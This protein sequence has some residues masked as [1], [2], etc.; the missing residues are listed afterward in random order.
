MI[1][2]NKE[3]FKKPFYFFLK[4]KGDKIS[5]HY[6][7]SNTLNEAKGTDN[8]V[9]IPKKNEGKLKNFMGKMMMKE[10]IPSLEY[11]T[12]KLKSYKKTALGEL[13]ETRLLV[14]IIMKAAKDYMKDKDFK[15][16]DEDKKFIK[17]QSI[18]V[19]K[20]IPLIVFQIF[21]GSSLAT[22]FIVEFA[23]KVGIKLTSE[24]PEKYKEKDGGE[25]DELVDIDG[26][27]LGSNIPILQQNMH[28]NKTLD[29]TVRMSRTTQ[30]PFIRV[31][32]GESE[33]KEGNLID[34]E[35]M[36]D[37]FGF[38]ETEDENTY[39]DCMKT[40]EEL[41]IDNPIERD[42]RCKTF[43]FEKKYDQQLDQ[44]KKQ[45]KCKNCFT[46]RRLSELENEKMETLLDEILLSKKKKD[47]DV[48]KNKEKD[49]DSSN[50]IEKILMRNLE[51]IAKI[52]DK[53]GI[54]IDKLVKHLKDSE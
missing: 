16:D 12:N 5:V 49:V 39:K 27:P 52:A 35:N 30:F 24:V 19:L 29:Q 50:P 34:E 42:E 33:E 22:P 1:E 43:G 36:S 2:F 6:S 53:E 25:I 41:G 54:D 17:D 14:K 11:I 18:D 4:D 8:V 31:Y 21:P 23:N 3:Y 26:S 51:S 28:P 40:M 10:S 20:L 37:A 48:V 13:K 38:D 46:K 7:V 44:E 15:L 45:G 47:N 32:Y 9:E